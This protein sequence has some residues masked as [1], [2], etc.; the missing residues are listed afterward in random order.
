VKWTSVHEEAV[1]SPWH[2][3]FAVMIDLRCCTRGGGF[4]AVWDH[5]YLCRS[6]PQLEL[7]KATNAT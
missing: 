2:S 1:A 7:N 5:L 6:L 4:P 3:L